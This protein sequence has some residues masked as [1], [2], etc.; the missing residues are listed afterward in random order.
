MNLHLSCVYTAS[1]LFYVVN[2]NDMIFD[3]HWSFMA[4]WKQIFAKTSVVQ[5][6]IFLSQI[7]DKLHVFTQIA[8]NIFH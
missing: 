3:I 6:F 5:S 2:V 4:S 1:N 8:G 7:D